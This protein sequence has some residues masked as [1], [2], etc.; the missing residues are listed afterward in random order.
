MFHR[1]L[2]VANENLFYYYIIWYFMTDTH[3]IMP[4]VGYLL[5]YFL[6]LS[7][8][9][10]PYGAFLSIVGFRETITATLLSNCA[11]ECQIV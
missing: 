11:I 9:W 5:F 2:Y 7:R 3:K 10:A 4:F 1:D 8:A 6:T